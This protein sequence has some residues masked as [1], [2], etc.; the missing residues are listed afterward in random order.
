MIALFVIKAVLAGIG[1][2]FGQSLIA[3]LIVLIVIG[4]VVF[5]FLTPINN[6]LREVRK[7]HGRDI[8]LEERHESEAGVI[9]IRP[10]EAD[11]RNS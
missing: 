10:H 9:S 11:T 7:A 5:A 2:G 8:E 3:H 1:I 4:P 6:R